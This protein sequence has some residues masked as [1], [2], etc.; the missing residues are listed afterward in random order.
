[1]LLNPPACPFHIGHR[2]YDDT[3]TFKGHV[4]RIIRRRNYSGDGHRFVAHTNTPWWGDCLE[5]RDR[6]TFIGRPPPKSETA[7][8][9]AIAHEAWTN[10]NFM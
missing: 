9:E 3:G 4:M 5:V 1:M 8:D 6:K 7:P 2:L 10:H